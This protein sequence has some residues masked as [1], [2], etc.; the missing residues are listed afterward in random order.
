MWVGVDIFENL[1]K[2]VNQKRLETTFFTTNPK[3]DRIAAK[4][5]KQQSAWL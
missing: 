4:T 2:D 3:N 1:K 5:C